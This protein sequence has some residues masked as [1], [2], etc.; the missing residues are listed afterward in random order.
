MRD[1]ENADNKVN[2]NPALVWTLEDAPEVS[3]ICNSSNGSYSLRYYI[4]L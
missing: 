4:G 1:M 3:V 2:L